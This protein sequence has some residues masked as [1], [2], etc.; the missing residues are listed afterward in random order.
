[1]VLSGHLGPLLCPRTAD[2]PVHHGSHRPYLNWS[3]APGSRIK[4]LLLD[5]DR[6]TDRKEA[7]SNPAQRFGDEPEVSLDCSPQ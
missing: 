5:P 7:D 1:M 2:R 4:V 3:P 6:D